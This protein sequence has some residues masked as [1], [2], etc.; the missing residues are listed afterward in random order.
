MKSNA[1]RSATTRSLAITAVFVLLTTV[2]PGRAVGHGEQMA[3]GGGGGPVGMTAEQRTAIGLETVEAT[4][5]DI[6]TVLSLNAV[7]ALDPDRHVFVSTRVEGRVE[8]ILV[9]LGQRVV[10]D[11]P[12]AVIQS[13]LLGNPPP[14]VTVTAPMA[15][16]VD[17]RLVAPGEAVD[18][19][20]TLFHIADLAQVIV[21]AEA[22]E[23]DVAK[24]ALD[25]PARMRVPAYPGESFEGTVTYV[26]QQ[27]DPVKRTLP[28]WITVA[29]PT[30]RLKPGMFAQATVILQQLAQVL[31][32]PRAALLEAG[33]ERFVFVD[34]GS[35]LVRTDVRAGASDDQF[36]EIAE[37]LV[38]GDRV[39]TQG[40]REVYTAW[41][42]GGSPP[43]DEH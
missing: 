1:T 11:Q 9:R 14:T 10:R 37:G 25:Q 31:A 13:R 3:T 29:N 32:V 33:G 19:S 36:V 24:V 7:V 22:Y 16:V 42:T 23:D 4:F 34:T 15:G 2:H 8:R 41:L 12:L 17:D 28:V 40:V 6:D 30:G 27:L 20:K 35:T 43:Q 39:V 26:G 5:H 21:Q 38:P 18:P